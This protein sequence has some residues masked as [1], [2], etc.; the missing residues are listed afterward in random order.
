MLI[1]RRK[2]NE[3]LLIGDSIRITIVDCA[4]DGVRIAIDAPR[5]ISII[6]EELS[7][8]EEMNKNAMAPKT[9]S[10]RFFQEAMQQLQNDKNS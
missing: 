5:Q 10:V 2:K 7:E 1:L 9:S 4:S 6:R 8:A 3:S